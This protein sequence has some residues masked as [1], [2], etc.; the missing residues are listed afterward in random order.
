MGG[1][2]KGS[3]RVSD[4]LLVF[5]MCVGLVIFKLINFQEIMIRLLKEIHRFY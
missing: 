2:S 3:S 4:W 1:I 5:N